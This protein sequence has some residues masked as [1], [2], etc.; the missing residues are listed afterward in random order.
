MRERGLDFARCGQVFNGTEATR[1]DVRFGYRETRWITVGLLDGRMVIVVWTERDGDRR[2]ISL[3][4][5]NER[6]QAQFGGRTRSTDV[7]R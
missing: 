4:K 7:S 5:A 6:E 3:R 1:E 2:I